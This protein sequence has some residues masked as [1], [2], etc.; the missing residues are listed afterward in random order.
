M[1]GQILNIDALRVVAFDW[2]NTLV[3]SREALVCSIN[4]V[5][6]KF[7]LGSWSE[8]CRLRDAN[9]SFRD[10]FPRIFG[11]EN[12]QEA[13]DDY[14]EVYRRCAPRIL[15]KPEYAEEVIRWFKHQGIHVVIVTN[16]DRRLW[17]FELPF[18]YETDLFERAVCGHEA[19]ADKPHPQQLEYAVHDMVDKITPQN[20]WMIGDSAMDSRCAL[21]AG[22]MAIRIGKSIW[23]DDTATENQNMVFVTDFTE[24]YRQLAG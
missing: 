13:Y 16:K 4:E 1:A 15:R 22:A 3:L 11:E 24:L 23:D 18:M 5:L 8:V 21:A 10:N 12:A 14:V 2:D 6:P 17:E 20:V 7:G 19:A 9:L